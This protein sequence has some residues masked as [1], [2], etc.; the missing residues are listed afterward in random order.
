M[1]STYE[2]LEEFGDLLMAPNQK[3]EQDVKARK[4]ELVDCRL[5]QLIAFIKGCDYNDIESSVLPKK[6]RQMILKDLQICKIIFKILYLM[7]VRIRDELY[8]SFKK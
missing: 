4:L 1:L 3:I 6:K 8:K 2:V 5:C 7:G